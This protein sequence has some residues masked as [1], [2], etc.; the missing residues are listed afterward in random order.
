MAEKD[1]RRRILDV[2]LER[3]LAD[4]YEQTTI[5]RIRKLSG[6]SNGGPEPAEGFRQNRARAESNRQPRP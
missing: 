2:A 5:A 1:T 4:G 3:F 6:V